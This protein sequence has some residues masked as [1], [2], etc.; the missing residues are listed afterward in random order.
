MKNRLKIILTALIAV[1]MMGCGKDAYDNCD[2]TAAKYSAVIVV[3]DSNKAAAT[4]NTDVASFSFTQV[5]PTSV[6]KCT[7]GTTSLKITNIT[8]QSITFDYVV[9][10]TLNGAPLWNY[11]SSATLAANATVD[12]GVI[13]TNN[14]SFDTNGLSL[15]TVVNTK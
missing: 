5:I 3:S 2:G 6:N 11:T 13:N 12:V 1:T 4:Y 8:S 9:N 14:T 10:V 15:S 7:P